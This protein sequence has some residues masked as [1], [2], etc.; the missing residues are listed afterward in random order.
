MLF[1]GLGVGKGGGGS[2]QAIHFSFTTSRHFPRWVG[3]IERGQHADIMGKTRTPLASQ[4]R[5][6]AT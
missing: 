4:Q 1:G 6:L 2:L 5:F 3:E